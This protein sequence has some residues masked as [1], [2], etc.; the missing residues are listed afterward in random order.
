MCIR[1]RRHRRDQ[2]PMTIFA[3]PMMILFSAILRIHNNVG[4]CQNLR[5]KGFKSRQNCRSDLVTRP[6]QKLGMPT[7]KRDSSPRALG[8]S[9]RI[10]ESSR[11]AGNPKGSLNWAHC[12]K[13]ASDKQTVT[14]CLCGD[15]HGCSCNKHRGRSNICHS[16]S[17][18][19]SSQLS[20]CTFASQNAS[21]WSARRELPFV[22]PEHAC[23]HPR[24]LLP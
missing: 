12:F 5:R 13:G 22:S 1:C 14:F 18:P 9:L 19:T 6:A 3:M 10:E 24:H 8:P 21:W 2:I 7:L 16:S 17:D 4:D 20:L 11:K 15:G 23:S